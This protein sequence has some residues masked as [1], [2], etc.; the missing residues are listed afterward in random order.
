MN[1]L[2][3]EQLLARVGR[4]HFFDARLWY[5]SV[6]PFS[7]DGCLALATAISDLLASLC[8][9]RAKV[10]AMDADNTLWGG[11]IG[12]DGLNGIALGPDHPGRAY[13]DFQ[14]RVL[15]LQ[16]RGFI[17]ALCSKNNPEDVEE[18]FREHPHEVL[19]HEH[20]AAERVN[21]LPKPDNLKSLAQ[22]LNFGLD[23]FIFVDDSDHE[24]A[25]VRHALP[26]VE[27]VKVP[28]RATEIPFFLDAVA[29]L[30]ITSLTSEDLRKTAMYAQE[31]Q[32]KSQLEQLAA[33]GGTVDEHLQSLDMRMRIAVDD[34]SVLPR[35]AQLTQKTNQFNLTTRRYSEQD[36]ASKLRCDKIAVYHFSLADRFGDSG[37]VGLAIVELRDSGTGTYGHLSDVV[38]RYRPSRGT[39]LSPL[40]HLRPA[41]KGRPGTLGGV[42]PHAQ[43]RPCRNVSAGQHFHRVGRRPLRGET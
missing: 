18:V 29:R 43:E 33:G 36:M 1:F 12:E 9:K 26:E 24:C 31:R 25:A 23:S 42:Y 38:P 17:L 35:L 19:K 30:E 14:K 4:D 2:D 27:V 28:A 5:S 34:D 13:L 22:E 11:V 16:Q 41:R 21:W 8:H 32:R 20:F 15:G 39:G 10:I 3:L 37:V 6:F 40:D 7:P